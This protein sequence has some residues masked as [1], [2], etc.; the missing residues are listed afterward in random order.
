M[1]YALSRVLRTT[2][3][4]RLMSQSH[5]SFQFL[6]ETKQVEQQ[7]NTLSYTISDNI[8]KEPPVEV[9]GLDNVYTVVEIITAIAAVIGEK[10]MLLH[11][12][13]CVKATRNGHV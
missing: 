5:L 4:V 11:F 10:N 6:N 1:D 3:D 13:W 7:Y 9:R 2:E 12:C 8:T